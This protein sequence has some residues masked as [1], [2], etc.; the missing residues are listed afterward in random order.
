MMTQPRVII[1]STVWPEPDSSAAGV[2]QMHWVHLFLGMGYGVTLVSPAKEKSEDDWGSITLPSGVDRLSLPLNRESIRDDLRA[3]SPAI[4]MFDRFF[5]EE[6]YGPHVYDACPNALILMETQ[7]LHFVRRARDGVKGAYL[8]TSELP[9]DFYRTESALRETAS[10]LRV[11][12]S[13]LVSS[14]EEQLLREEFGLGSA[15]VK[16]VPFFYERPIAVKESRLPFG[17]KKDFCWIG[18]FRHEPNIDGLRWFRQEIWPLI[19]AQLP[20]ARIHVYGAYPPK[21][22][23]DWNNARNGFE[24][25]GSALTLEEVFEEARVNVA[26][27]RFGAGVKGKIIEGFRFGVPCVT[28][29]VGVE[30][31]FGQFPGIEANTPIDFANACVRLHESETEWKKFSLMALEKM[32][33]VCAASARVP[34]LRQLIESLQARKQG[35]DLPDWTSRV[36]R[37]EANFSRIYFAKWIEEKEKGQ[38]QGHSES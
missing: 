6:Q 26:P 24:V 7:D 4:V 30:G 33:E 10:I 28:T 15:K 17:S 19:R 18:N 29:K 22:V 11:D 8:T 31:L 37:S 5:L 23:M 27:L 13:F 21:E 12:F 35:G 14:F 32:M 38:R 3:L 34:E 20:D 1:F 36:L 25:K 16:W 9:R 2:R